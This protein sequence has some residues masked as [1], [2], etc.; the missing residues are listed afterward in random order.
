M[1]ALHKLGKLAGGLAGLVAMLVIL[2][3]VNVIVK[4]LRMTRFDLTEEKLYTLSDGTRTILE[5]LEKDV[6]L[7]F[8]FS[9]SSAEVPTWLKSFA[10][11]IEDL[12]GE[13]KIAS[14]GHLD[15]KLLDPK[16][17]SD[18]EDW[19]REAG[20]SGT[21]LQFMGPTVYIGVV[22]RSGDQ[23][24]VLPAL[25]P[26]T[27][28]ELE[29]NLIRLVHRAAHPEKPVIG[30]LSSLPV[31]GVQSPPFA[32]PGQPQPPP[33]PAWLLFKEL[34]SDYDVRPVAATAGEI[35]QG[36]EALIVVHPKDLPEPMTFAIDQFLLRGGKLLVFLDPLSV[37]D[38]AMQAA[39]G[40]F[41]GRA[42]PSSDLN[43]LL[44]AWGITYNPS[45]VLADLSATTPTR[46]RG[47]DPTNLRLFGK[48]GHMHS[49]DLVTANL[50][51][52]HL[53]FAGTFGGD[54]I[55]SLTMTPLLSSSPNSDMINS[56]TIRFGPDAL[57][58][59]FTSG[60][61]TLPLAVR[62]FGRFKT[63]FPDGAPDGG[64]DASG[65]DAEE[66][67]PA[68]LLTESV[69][70]SA[71]ILVGDVDMLLDEVC[72]ERFQVFG[73]SA[74]RPRN[75]NM[76]FFANAVEQLAGSTDLIGVRTRGQ[77]V[78]PFEVVDRLELQAQ[79]R[80]LQEEQVLQA[81][82]N[83][84]R[85]RLSELQTQKDPSQRSIISPEQ[86]AAIKRFRKEELDTAKKLKGVRKELR[87]EIDQLGARIKA[88]NIILM[89]TLV[90]LSGIAFGLYRRSRIR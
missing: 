48:A 70:D 88:L 16:P 7:E 51:M 71:V 83:E 69:R 86:Q 57:K 46:D 2:V 9:R 23:I 60:M 78:R 62:L 76:N 35:D 24:A 53:P 72:I 61:T 89:P 4:N 90:G 13:F 85:Q 32:M 44:M 40:Q 1:S 22:A 5:N 10:N 74:Y 30:V 64:D 15:V 47:N 43:R 80:W 65:E 36:I 73:S 59:E 50:E 54:P 41:G 25:H 81:A 87:K 67:K 52:L 19:A 39:G 82:L 56:T 34:E 17:D 8:Y 27:A 18:E 75:D 63:A 33:Q 11:Q 37:A 77:S 21:Q 26:D 68:N 20:I 12:L 55:E 45:E 31:L 14:A 49:N 29:Y 3:A 28:P 84:A 58:R 6:S 38:P 66:P 42:Q 79:E